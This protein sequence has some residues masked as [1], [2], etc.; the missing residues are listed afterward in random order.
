MYFGHVIPACI[1]VANK[2]ATNGIE[3][4]FIISFLNSRS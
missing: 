2:S 3:N 1:F 4:F